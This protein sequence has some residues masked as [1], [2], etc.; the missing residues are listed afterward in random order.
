LAS[1]R[2]DLSSSAPYGRKPEW[3]TAFRSRPWLA[4]GLAF[5]LVLAATYLL[6]QP[7]TALIPLSLALLVIVAVSLGLLW[8]HERERAQRL[9]Q[10]FRHLEDLLAAQGQ[11]LAAYGAAPLSLP[12]DSLFSD[13]LIEAVHAP[14]RPAVQAALHRAHG[15]IQAHVR[16]T[17]RLALDLRLSMTL[18]PMPPVANETPRLIAV[19]LDAS[20]QHA[21]EEELAAAQHEAEAQNL[22]KSR[23]LANVSHELRTPL[24]AVIGFSD[25]MAQRLFGP[26]SDR[27]AD[28]AQSISDAGNHLLDLIGDLLDVSRIEADRYD[29]S[30]ESLDV[31]EIVASALVLMRITAEEKG[32][33]LS[34]LMPPKPLRVMADRRALK[35]MT[36]NLLSNAVKFTPPGGSV[37]VNA[38]VLG[39]DLEL[40]VADTGLGIAPEDLARLGRPFEQAGEA[41]Q[42]AQGTGLGL[43]LVRSLAELHQ[44]QMSIDST[45]GSGTAVTLRLP[46][47]EPESQ[48]SPPLTEA[49]II[50]LNRAS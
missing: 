20:L 50:P 26:L 48:K 22:A 46:I 43:S 29:L 28:Y 16:F 14:D 13:G 45:L 35:Q 7:V 37:T 2:P 32:V 3:R 36:L 41:G 49:E 31:R 17:P 44:G 8:R 11:P 10:R 33:S 18:R 47:I 30:L 19:I 5:G 34:A 38:T 9:E 21:R 23:V 4:P 15:G 40:V 27:Y 42:R 25:I 6:P 24:N 1:R 12:I 39:P